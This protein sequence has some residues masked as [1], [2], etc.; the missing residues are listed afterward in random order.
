MA[1]SPGQETV[2]RNRWR[3]KIWNDTK[4][5]LNGRAIMLIWDQFRTFRC[6]LFSKPFC[7]P[8]FFLLLFIARLLLHWLSFLTHWIHQPIPK[9]WIQIFMNIL[10]KMHQKQS[11]ALKHLWK[12]RIWIFRIVGSCFWLVSGP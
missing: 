4:L 5:I 9:L 11:E 12:F 3:L 8:W 7:C 1:K 6:P 2:L 10:T